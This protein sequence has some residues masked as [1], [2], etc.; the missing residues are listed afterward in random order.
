MSLMIK[1]DHR[2]DYYALLG[3]N[4]TDDRETIRS[5]Y[6]ELARRLHT[7]VTGNTEANRVRFSEVAEAW[8]VLSHGDTRARYDKARISK[9]PQVAVLN[10]KQQRDLET[11]TQAI[12]EVRKLG[13]DYEDFTKAYDSFEFWLAYGRIRAQ[14]KKSRE[15]GE[16][17]TIKEL[18]EIER[19]A[20]R[21]RLDVKTIGDV[22]HR[23]NVDPRKLLVILNKYNDAER[24]ASRYYFDIKEAI[25]PPI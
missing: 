10:P 7:D 12:F 19:M 22:A 3:A 25:W 16:S 13:I 5:K 4:T 23:T 6:W 17:I 20:K 24:I 8:A 14:H 2:K 18:D 15:K 11:I 21:T 9:K 1:F